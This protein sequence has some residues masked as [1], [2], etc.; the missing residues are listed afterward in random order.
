MSPWPA[1]GT[2][3]IDLPRRAGLRPKEY[4]E[5]PRRRRQGDGHLRIARGEDWIAER[6]SDLPR[7]ADDLPGVQQPGRVEDALDPRE[8]LG[9]LWVIAVEK[10]G[11]RHPQPLL[12][13]DRATDRDD[14]VV[15]SLGEAHKRRSIGGIPRIGVRAD[16]ELAVAS[17]PEDHRRRGAAL[18]GSLETA[19][20][21]RK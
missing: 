13:A 16:M 1:S 14:L 20:E 5:R 8:H 11:P 10:T 21:I 2:R 19:K 17:M 18:E 4:R 9:Q 12:P 15:D 3:R 7:P 6:E